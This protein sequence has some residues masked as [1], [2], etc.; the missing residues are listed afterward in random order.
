MG[1]VFFCLR[2][3]LHFSASAFF[4]AHLFLSAPMAHLR[5]RLCPRE[6]WWGGYTGSIAISPSSPGML[7]H[8]H[9]LLYS[10]VTRL[11][12]IQPGCHLLGKKV[13]THGSGIYFY[14]FV[15]FRKYGA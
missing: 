1:I 6:R 13:R 12:S 4:F 5:S 2:F 7:P 9:T 14:G 11:T 15:F 8:L 3:S 10:R